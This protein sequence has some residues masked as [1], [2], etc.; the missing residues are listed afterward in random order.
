MSKKST[1]TSISSDAIKAIEGLRG[2]PLTFGR[3]IESV[4]IRDEISQAELARRMNISRSHLC[5]IEKGRRF[6]RAARAAKFAKALGYSVSVFVATALDDELRA[7]GL[8]MR[9]T[10]E[11]A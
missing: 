10:L 1:N 5:D 3:M 7:A 6:V 11:A 8:S 9:V 2:G 4:R